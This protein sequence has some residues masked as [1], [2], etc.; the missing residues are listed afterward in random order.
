MT[1]SLVQVETL[2]PR[3]QLRLQAQ[4]PKTLNLLI[5]DYLSTLDCVKPRATRYIISRDLDEDLQGKSR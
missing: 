5:C 1:Y 4:L 3:N 2:Q